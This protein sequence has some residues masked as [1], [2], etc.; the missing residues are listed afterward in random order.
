[1]TAGQDQGGRRHLCEPDKTSRKCCESGQEQ[2][3]AVSQAR[4]ARGGKHCRELDKS[5]RWENTAVSR[6]DQQDFRDA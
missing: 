4:A 3:D 5:G 6:A 1:M 2:R